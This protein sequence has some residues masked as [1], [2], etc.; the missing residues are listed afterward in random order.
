MKYETERRQSALDQ[1]GA[2]S[3]L[4]QRSLWEQAGAMSK[5]RQSG[6]WEEA[7]GKGSRGY[8]HNR[9]REAKL[10]AREA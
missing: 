10:K 8:T 3:K 6:L 7:G 5:L 4:K 2:V 9:T 1:S